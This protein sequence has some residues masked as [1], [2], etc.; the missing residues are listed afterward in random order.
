M[1]SSEGYYIPKALETW[2][3]PRHINPHQ[4]DFETERYLCKKGPAS[5]QAKYPHLVRVLSYPA[6]NPICRPAS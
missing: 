1:P 5:F 2:K 3:W 4:W 6:I